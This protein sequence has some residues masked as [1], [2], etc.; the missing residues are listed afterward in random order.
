MSK[1]AY[2]QKLKEILSLIDDETYIQKS[3]KLSLHLL[4]LLNDLQV[5]QKNW[6]IG[7]FAPIGT[8]PLWNLVLPNEFDHNVAFPSFGDGDHSMVFRPSEVGKLVERA[9]FGVS[10]LGPAPDKKEVVPD[11][12]LIPGLGF[13][14]K[15]QRLG[16]GKGYYD[17]YLENFSGLKIGICFREQLVEDLPVEDHDCEMDIVVTEKN[18]IRVNK[19]ET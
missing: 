7:V 19:R 12:L 16:R 9:D 8:E 10:I 15:G 13:N 11:V 4:S 1:Q 6:C 18:I 17:R 3:L 5:I 14:H 2:R